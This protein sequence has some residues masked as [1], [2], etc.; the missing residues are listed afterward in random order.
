MELV[1]IKPLPPSAALLV[2]CPPVFAGASLA[3]FLAG[4]ALAA[5]FGFALTG[6]FPTGLASFC[7]FSATILGFALAMAFS[8]SAGGFTATE[9]RSLEPGRVG[10]DVESQRVRALKP[11]YRPGDVVALAAEADRDPEL[12]GRKA[13]P[14]A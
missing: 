4:G 3:S 14:L 9:Q 10:D 6:G 1:Q 13:G 8:C 5:A 2:G 12:D 7:G 11:P